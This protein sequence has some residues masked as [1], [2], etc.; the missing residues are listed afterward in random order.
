MATADL[1]L[2][3]ATQLSELIRERKASPVEV[4]QAALKHIESLEPR[5][6]AFV[7]LLPDQAMDAA[8][9]AEAEISSGRYLGPLHGIPFGAKDIIATE[10]VRTTADSKVLENWVPTFDAAVVKRLKNA[11]AILIGKLHSHEFAGG[12]ATSFG[13]TVNPWNHKRVPG[14]SSSGSAAAVAGGFCPIALGTDTGGSIRQP[15]S[16]CG[17]VGLKATY[18]RISRHGVLPLSWSL[19]HVGPMTRS[20]SDAAIALAALAGRDK[21]DG[22]SRRVKVPDYAASLK[23]DLTGIRIGV[24][25]GHFSSP[26]AA[27]VS[28]VVSGALQVLLANGASLR[29]IDL[30][31]VKHASAAYFAISSAEALSA[32]EHWLEGHYHDYGDDFRIRLLQGVPILATQYL[33]AQKMRTLIKNELARV[34]KDVD[35]LVSPTLPVP[36]PQF[37]QETVTINGADENVRQIMSR[38]TAPFNLSG[39]PAISI[40]CGFSEEQLPIGLQLVGRAF[41]EELLLR[42]AYA[43]EQTAGIPLYRSGGQS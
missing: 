2:A 24:L 1:A 21:L 8:K 36:A 28:V 17:I 22:S 20:V 25:E 40:P 5:L 33:R 23:C 4:M 9:R 3:T 41:D 38:F 7:T 16:F 19:D 32:H 14:S 10:G 30:K 43:Y 26:V 29:P 37:G 18:G 35:V 11:G 39:N 27:D 15:A 42:V 6:N 13:P 12:S 31:N 34:F